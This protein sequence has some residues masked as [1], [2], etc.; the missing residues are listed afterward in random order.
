MAAVYPGSGFWLS[1]DL[2]VFEKVLSANCCGSEYVNAVLDL[3]DR[4]S[5]ELGASVASLSRTFSFS[6]IQSSSCAPQF[7]ANLPSQPK[8]FFPKFDFPFR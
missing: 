1:G 2:F 4:C 3:D 8:H 5:F 6:H 7:V